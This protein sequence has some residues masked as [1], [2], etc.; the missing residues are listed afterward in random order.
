MD[1]GLDFVLSPARV[2]A[3]DVA[4]AAARAGWIGVLNAEFDREPSACAHSLAKLTRFGRGRIGLKLPTLGDDFARLLRNAERPVDFAVISVDGASAES[5]LALRPYASKIVLELSAWSDFAADLA[6]IADIVWL[7]GHESGGFVGEQTSFVLLR[8][9]VGRTQKPLCIRGGVNPDSAAAARVG[10]AAGVVLDDQLLLM[11]ESPLKEAWAPRLKRFSGVETLLCDGGPSGRRLRFWG[12][13]GTGEARDLAAS[14][15]RAGAVLP[16]H[17]ERLG[18]GADDAGPLIPP[19]GQD[20]ALAHSWADKYRSTANALRAMERAVRDLPRLAADLDPFGEDSALAK[21]HGTRFPIVQGPMTHVSDRP[22]FAKAVADAGALPMAAVSL[23]RGRAVKDLLAECKE[24]VG[25]A[26]WGVGMLGFVPPETLADQRAALI[27]SRPDFAI[28]AGGR[29]DQARD[30]EAAGIRTYLHVPSPVLLTQFVEQDA[31]CFIFEGRECGGHIGPLSS[32]VLWHVMTEALLA[33][34]FSAEEASERKILFAG[35][36]HDAVSAAMAAVMAARLA[37]A[38]FEV[39]V[40]MGTGYIFTREAVETGAIT[41][42]FQ[43]I[44]LAAERTASL[45]TG[46]GHASRCADTPF[47]EQFRM[48]RIELEQAGASPAEVSKELEALSLGRLRL[49]SKGLARKSPDA[50]DL[51]QR[52]ESEQRSGGMYMIGQAASLLNHVMTIAE[53]HASV[54]LGSAEEIRRAVSERIAPKREVRAAPADIAI[55]GVSAILPGAASAEDYWRNILRKVDAVGE[56]PIER[57]DVSDYFDPDRNARDKIYSRWGGFVPDIRF[58]PAAF[59]MPPNSVPSIDP[60]Q[61]MAL[62]AIR[63]AI[64]DA[65]LILNP[66]IAERTSV[67]LGFSGGLGELG[68]KYATRTELHRAGGASPEALAFLPEWSEDSFAG[69]LPNVAAGR[70]ANRFDFGGVNFT[71]DAACASSLAALYQAALE[72]KSGRSD[73]VITGGVDTVQGPFG[74]TCF[75]KAQA[76]SQTG[77]SRTFDANSDGIAISEGVAMIVLKRL[78]DAERDG[79]RIYAVIKGVGGSSDGKAKGLMAPHPLGQKRALRRAYEDAGYSPATVGL[80]EAHGTGTVVGDR[81][82]LESLTD[83]LKEG[84]AAP[85]SSVVGSVKTMIGHTKS[86]AGMAGLIKAAF[87]LHH[88]VLPPHMGVETPNPALADPSSPLYLNQEL[89]PWIRPTAHP[90]RAGVSS[91]GFGG[92]NFHV[93]LEEYTQEYRRRATPSL[94][95]EWPVELFVWR[96]ADRPALVAAMRR[97]LNDL[98]DAESVRPAVLAAKLAG[99]APQVGIGAAIVA[100]TPKVLAEKLEATIACVEGRKEALPAGAYFTDSPLGREGKLAFVFSGQGSQYPDMMREL[101]ARAPAFRTV[102]EAAD[103]ATR[104]TPT[105]ADGPPLSRR[106]YPPERFTPAEE[107]AAAKALMRTDVTQP[108]LAAVEAGAFAYL[109]ELGVRPDMMCGHSF[110][111]FAALYAANVL[112]ADDLFGIA[113]ARGRAIVDAA[114][115]TGLGSMIAALAPESEVR[116]ALADC[117]GVYVANY[118]GPKQIILSG[119]DAAV[120]EALRRL[121]QAGIAAKKIPVSA[122]F[123]SPLMEPARRPLAAYLSGRRWRDPEIPVYSNATAEPHGNAPAI[124]RAMVEHLTGPVRFAQTVEAMHAAGAR[125]FLEVGPRT[126]LRDLVAANLLGKP[127]VAVAIDGKGGDFAGFIHALAILFVHAAPVDVAALTATRADEASPAA[128]AAARRRLPLK[129]SEWLINGG[130]AKKPGAA[131]AVKAAPSRPR[132]EKPTPRIAEAAAPTNHSDDGWIEIKG[133]ATRASAVAAQEL[134]QEGEPVVTSSQDRSGG[135]DPPRDGAVMRDYFALMRQFVQSQERV[136]RSWLGAG[137][138][139][140]GELFDD[141]FAQAASARPTGA[142][143]PPPSPP[144]APERAPERAAAT[145]SSVPPQA[146]GATNG[147]ANGHATPQISTAPSRKEPPAAAPPESKGAPADIKTLLL[148]LVSDRTGYPEDMLTLDADIEGDLGID[149]IKRTEILGVMRKELPSGASA[150]LEQRMPELAKAKSLGQIIAIVKETL[151]GAGADPQPAAANGSASRPFE[152]GGEGNLG[153]AALPRFIIKAHAEPTDGA[154]LSDPLPGAYVVLAGDDEALGRRLVEKIEKAGGRS[155]LAPASLWRDDIAFGRWLGDIKT[156]ETIRAIVNLG[157]ADDPIMPP[158]ASFEDWDR[159]IERD[160]KSF[161]PVLQAAADD[162]KQGGV[163]LAVSAMGGLFAR[164][165]ANET[166]GNG[167]PWPAPAGTIGLLKCLSLEWTACRCKAIDLDPA[168]SLEARADQAFGE[169]FLPGGRREVGYPGGVRT[170]FRT[171]PA[172]LSRSAESPRL[173][174]RDWVVLAIGGMRGVTAEALRDLAKA[175]ATLVLVSRTGAPAEED[176][177]LAGCRDKPALQ[178]HFI[179]KARAAGGKFSPAAVESECAKVLR[180]REVRANLADFAAFGSRIDCRA[181]DVRDATAVR[182]L[183]SSLYAQY[184][185]IDAVVYGAGVIEDQL[186]VNKSRESVARVIGAKTDGVFHLSRELRPETLKFFGIF[187]SVAGRYG[188]RG[189]TDYGAANEILNQYA[190][191]LRA[192]WGSAVKVAAI[193]WGPWAGTTHGA[194]MVTPET[195]RLFEARG[196]SLIEPEAGLGFMTNEI[197]HATSDEVEVVAG[198]NPWEH[199]EAEHGAFA[200]RSEDGCLK[201]LPLLTGRASYGRSGDELVVRKRIDLASDPYL[202]HHRIEGKPVMPFVIGAEHI[203]EAAA[204]FEGFE[205][206]VELRDIRFFKGVTLTGDGVDIEL[207]LTADGT[208][209]LDAEMRTLGEKPVRAYAAKLLK[210]Q[211]SAGVQKLEVPGLAAAPTIDAYRDWLFHGPLFQTLTNITSL[212]ARGLRAEVRPSYPAKFYPPAKQGAWLFDPGVLDGAL[213]CVLVWSRVMR[214]ETALPTRM[215]RLARFG[216]EALQGPLFIDMRFL[217]EPGVSSSVCDFTVSDAAGRVRYLVERLE[218]ASTRA[219]NRIGGRLATGVLETASA[220]SGLA[221]G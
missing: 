133:L 26:P 67:I 89:R 207:R 199:L 127:H 49:A 17:A 32:F 92:T 134:F 3:V 18:W 210:A 107:A 146:N 60:L 15:A 66:E 11:A 28:I 48:R 101:A 93:T 206:A 44:A 119:G 64:D 47:V 215:G 52:S 203:A 194:G 176:A 167:F 69:L 12:P 8:D 53:L 212:D 158:N 209:G 30:L 114:G 42:T 185:R 121:E 153:G 80:F 175:G 115:E 4:I 116:A 155:Y 71:V 9:S 43:K 126:V 187:T 76:L 91:F 37:D 20:G 54:S 41:E 150:S 111:E 77:R 24:L 124:R 104:Q 200:P 180:E 109:K 117:P 33:A 78:A 140:G 189:Q 152:S 83:V 145:P 61:L 181:A 73:I 2:D 174:G 70:A 75:A 177:A 161:F 112:S 190:H 50:P 201:S 186:L 110:G 94:D 178:Q 25:D 122:A 172:S 135:A 220:S 128:I 65:G 72:L 62:A 195:R 183:V 123:H 81:T 87:A 171:L 58:D 160:V 79:D 170:I 136:M 173:P 63:D 163:V 213:Q 192:R 214:D 40:L 125:I 7:K 108:A 34:K 198:D 102:L 22:A 35:G 39:G 202:D 157:P 197:L 13:P 138:P 29:P 217:T 46:P 137:Q 216:D 113:E 23:M 86:S 219:L 166:E 100:C 129:P 182:E 31:R 191:Q 97:T 204:L 16:C 55:V 10:G 168:Q 149:S 143:P 5:M 98:S 21:T 141:A 165:A 184:G 142:L 156:Q 131:P 14:I 162:L 144:P 51:S 147:T 148:A 193:N 74:F 205:R 130:Q 19:L 95:V 179:A 27:E 164:G 85:R 84:G 132:Q 159:R 82:E 6:K 218:A 154:I 169:L 96:G 57:W 56:I 68:V 103:A 90:R 1:G 196:V 88:K 36:I 208:G 105:F 211:G 106:I 188:N 38:G 59:G 118:N 120:D 99:A 221:H 45:A 151:S 139:A